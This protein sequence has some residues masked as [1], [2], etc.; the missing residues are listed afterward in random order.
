MGAVIDYN[1]YTVAQLKT[2]LDELG[3]AYSSSAKK[4]ELIAL[5]GG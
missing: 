5:L 4:A 2:M 3:I 1:S